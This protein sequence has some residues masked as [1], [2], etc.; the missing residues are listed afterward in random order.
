MIA[1]MFEGCGELSVFAHVD[2]MAVYCSRRFSPCEITV[3]KLSD[4]SHRDEAVRLCRARAA[5][6]KNAAVYADG[7]YVYLLCTEKN[8]EILDFLR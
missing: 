3:M 1:R 4:R 2:A 6:K 5:K 8:A 7:V